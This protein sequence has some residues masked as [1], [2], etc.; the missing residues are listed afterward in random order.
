[1][2]RAYTLMRKMDR[3]IAALR[4]EFVSSSAGKTPQYLRF[5]AL[6][7]KEFTSFLES[8]GCTSVKIQKPNHFDVSGFFLSP[9]GEIWYFCLGDIR[10]WKGNILIRTAESFSDYEGGRNQY[11]PLD[12]SE[13]LRREIV[14]AIGN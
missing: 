13:G 3:T 6:F 5:H 1:M 7:K 10:W 2:Q 11:A 9:R 12:S 4:E 8:L 14:R